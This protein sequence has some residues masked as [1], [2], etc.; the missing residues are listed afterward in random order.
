M[1]DKQIN[2]LNDLV[3][4]KASPARK[5]GDEN[6]EGGDFSTKKNLTAANSRAGANRKSMPNADSL[7]Q[8]KYNKLAIMNE[9]LAAGHMGSID[10]GQKA[11]N[12]KSNS[13]R[14]VGN[15][16]RGSNHPSGPLDN[17]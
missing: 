11:P 15:K 10:I 9:K 3:K 8:F 12:S 1:K 16:Y 6:G 13:A 7:M 2:N 14:A 17:I 4:H 5:R